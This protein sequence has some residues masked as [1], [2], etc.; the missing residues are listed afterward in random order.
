MLRCGEFSFCD[1]LKVKHVTAELPSAVLFLLAVTTS[2]NVVQINL[3]VTQS[4]MCV[5]LLAVSWPGAQSARDNH[6]ISC[7][8]VKFSPILIFF[9]TDR[10]SNKP[11]LIWFLAI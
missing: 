1:F 6:F 3:S 8:F 11:L 2:V 10:L 9:F 5:C 7:N 4:S